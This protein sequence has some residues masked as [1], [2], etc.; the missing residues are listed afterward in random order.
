MSELHM[1]VGTWVSGWAWHELVRPLGHRGDR[2][3]RTTRH[4]HSAHKQI[5]TALTALPKVQ[6][7]CRGTCGSVSTNLKKLEKHGTV[8][9]AFGL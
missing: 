3:I 8:S 4:V 5:Q 1:G 6:G 2:D 7:G 9:R